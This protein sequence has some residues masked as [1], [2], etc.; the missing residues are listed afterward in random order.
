MGSHTRRHFTVGTHD[1]YIVRNQPVSR[2][3][4]GYTWIDDGPAKDPEITCS[5]RYE[6]REEYYRKKRVPKIVSTSFRGSS[7]LFVL[8]TFSFAFWNASLYQYMVKGKGETQR[9]PNRIRRDR[10]WPHP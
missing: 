4:K 9:G 5:D 10:E 3:E 2:M 8:L 1:D 6:H 7:I